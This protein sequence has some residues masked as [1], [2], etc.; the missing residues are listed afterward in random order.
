MDSG[1][2]D[3]ARNTDRNGNPNVF[4]L[5]WNGEQLKLNG[6]NAKPAKQWN[7]NNKFVFRFRK[8]FLFPRSQIA[9]FLLFF[10]FGEVALLAYRQAGERDTSE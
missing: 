4:N 5:N 1:K 2:D 8:Y 6:N 7:G 10:A 3:L 9:V